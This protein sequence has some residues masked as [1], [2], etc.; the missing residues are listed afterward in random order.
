MIVANMKFSELL[1]YLAV[2]L[3][4]DIR[5]LFEMHRAVR[6]GCEKIHAKDIALLR[7]R[8]VESEAIDAPFDWNASGFRKLFRGR[9]G[10]GG[11]MEAD[12]FALGFFLIAYLTDGPRREAAERAVELTY[13]KYLPRDGETVCPLTGQRYFLGALKTILTNLEVF[14]RAEIIRISSDAG[15]ARIEFNESYSI[16]FVNRKDDP[17]KFKPLHR[18][19]VLLVPALRSIFDFIN[20]PET[21]KSKA[22]A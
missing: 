20:A 22:M 9:P 2:A 21:S 13:A 16:F 15:F 18:E 5:D 10:P 3:R 4:E 6:E 7:A 1:A 14:D 19:H 12:A 8:G 17:G 11:G